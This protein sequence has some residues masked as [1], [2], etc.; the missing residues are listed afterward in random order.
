MRRRPYRLAGLFLVLTVTLALGVMPEGYFRQIMFYLQD[1][2]IDQER[3]AQTKPLLQQ[4]LRALENSAD[5]IM[6]EERPGSTGTIYR[7]LVNDHS[8]TVTDA[9]AS[10]PLKLAETLER[11]MRFVERWYSGTEDVDDLRYAVANG[12]ASA[13]DPHTNVFTPKQYKE[14]F[15]HIE[16]EI[17]GIG[18]YIGVR[19]GKLLIIAPLKNSPAMRAGIKAGDEI[20]RIDDE[21]TVSMSTQEAVSKIRGE[22]GTPVT[23]VIRRKGVNRLIKKTIIRDRIEIKSVE[24]T[25]LPGQIGYIK[26]VS[27]AQNTGASFLNH[28]KKLIDKNRGP[29]R[30]LVLDLRD[31]PGGLLDQAAFL[32]DCF[33]KSGPIVL[34]AHKGRVF[35]AMRAKD[36]GTEPECPVVV[37][38]NQGSASG[39]EILAGAL[40]NNNRALLIGQQT[41]G[42]GSVQQPRPL[43]DKSCLKLTVYEFLLPGQVSIQNVGVTPDI[44]LDPAIIEKDQVQ[45]FAEDRAM[46]ERLHR[47]AIIS[48]FAKEERPSWRI[49]YYLDLPD[50]PI[51]IDEAARS[52]VEG[53]FDLKSP[54]F[55]PVHLACSLIRMADPS[56]PF[57]RLSFLTLHRREIQALKEEKFREV[58]AKLKEAG[59]DWRDGPVP[60]DPKLS[61]TVEYETIVEPP[62]H[63]S[64]K[65]G[66]EALEEEDPT[67]KRKVVLKATA[68][69]KG[70]TPLYRIYGKTKTEDI[71]SVYAEREFLF[72]YLPPGASVTRTVSIEIP[73][74]AVPQ[75]DTFT[76]EVGPYGAQPVVRKEVKV[77]ISTAPTPYLAASAELTDSKG[78]PVGV[79]EVGREYRLHVKVRNAGKSTIYQALARLKNETEPSNAVFLVRGRNVMRLLKPGDT[80]NFEFA[81]RVKGKPEK[82]AYKFRLDVFETSSA[83]GL[84][85]EFTVPA[86]GGRPFKPLVLVPPQLEAKTEALLTDKDSIKVDA[87][88]KDDSTVRY[89]MILTISRDR[90]HIDS[91]PDK[92]VF[93][94]AEGPGPHRFTASV[95]LQVGTNLV[96]VV[97]TDDMQLKTVRSFMVKRR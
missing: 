9:D 24:S 42:K 66:E 3:L 34:T 53:E 17:C 55:V 21:S 88:V 72:G 4:A 82:G 61:V 83:R 25:L 19:D 49:I 6:V 20:V 12:M 84:T 51:D 47:R 54:E 73:Y 95:P 39:S 59:I 46:Q 15:V 40:R 85:K 74:Y 62:E 23:L 79:L 89:F 33:L 80:R 92:V 97:A 36:D 78:T 60:P 57:D 50:N 18:A 7:I 75:E 76:L 48:K 41:F 63:A 86:P 93:R 28:L 27:F 96:S 30:G 69:N 56:E 94:A 87:L 26:V 16:G 45:V 58:V 68:T 43:S 71:T 35:Q 8:M 52:F 2:Y 90:A 38:V 70:K 22:R 11:V 32:A 29:L 91:Y 44:A 77:K 10:T 31:N 67:P 37:L 5:E 14:F 65:E 13:L 81:F 64:S 1:S